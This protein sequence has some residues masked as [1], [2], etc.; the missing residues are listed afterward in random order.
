MVVS[1]VEGGWICLRRIIGRLHCRPGTFTR[2]TCDGLEISSADL[3]PKN[4]QLGID[5]R[6]PV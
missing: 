2:S 5:W 1:A 3:G 4:I 6:L